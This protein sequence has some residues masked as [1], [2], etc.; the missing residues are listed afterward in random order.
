MPGVTYVDGYTVPNYERRNPA[1]KY[2]MPFE[3]DLAQR[4]MQT[5][6]EFDI[7]LFASEPMIVK[8][9]AMN[10]DER[11][12]LWV[13]ESRD[14]PNVVLNGLPGNDEIKILEDTNGDGKADKVTIFADKIN[15]ATSLTFANGGVIV[16]AM[17][18]M[19]FFKDTNGDD[20]ADV[21]QV[22]STGWGMRDTHGEASNLQY[23]PDNYIWGSVGYNGGNV[24]GKQFSQGAYRFKPDGS[25]FEVMVQSTNN[26]WG[27]G[28]NE[29][30]DV[31]GSTANGDPSW[32]MGIPGRFFEGLTGLPAGGGRA[33]GPPVGAR[34][35]RLSEPRAVHDRALH[36][37]VH[38]AG[39]Q[40]GLLHRRCGAHVLHGAR[41]SEGV[42]EPHRVHQ[43]ADGAH[44][45]P[46]HRRAEG[47]RVRHARRVEPRLERGG[48]VRADCVAGWS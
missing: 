41:V 2:Q 17:P 29:S 44:R 24:N 22:L 45:R 20:K 46:G 32:Y 14:Y 23:G 28:F 12:R 7:Q 48:V 34:D 37:A 8:P 10:F 39:R 18:N 36:D 27:L 42:L 11:G 13:I 9:I 31:F 21:R 33:G 16:A 38:P 15:L 40:H 47:R 1:P 43:R 3:P 25:N 4:F 6:A 30:F 35:A 26:T 19:L 5:P